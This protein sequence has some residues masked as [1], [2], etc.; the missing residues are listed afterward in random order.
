MTDKILIP[1]PGIG[2]LELSAEQYAK[3]LRP[4]QATMA[5]PVAPSA[6]PNVELL[7]A[8]ETALRFSLPKSWLLEKARQDVIPHK[9]IGRYVRFSPVELAGWLSRSGPTAVRSNGRS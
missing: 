8:D 7:T 4:L 9:R 5:A 6:A 2:T 3:A 1:L